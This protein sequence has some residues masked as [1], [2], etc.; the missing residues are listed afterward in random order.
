[1]QTSHS[2]QVASSEHVSI[3]CCVSA[4]GNTIPPYIIYKGAFPGGSYTLGG[5]NSA[6]YSKQ[7]SGFMDSDLFLKWLI[8][9]FIP[10]TQPS[11][12]NKPVLLLLDGHSS[13]CMLDV[14]DAARNNHVILLALAPHTTHLCK[15]LNVAVYKAFKVQL[16]KLKWLR[17]ALRRDLWIAKT[18]IARMIRGPFEQSMS[19]ENIK[20][21]F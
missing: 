14:I 3:H 18:S 4:M 9:L 13:H 16:S 5:P 1:M 11:E 17:Q 7:Q 20:S 12:D 8:N 10:Q 6:M 21:C 19:I 2:R 15:P